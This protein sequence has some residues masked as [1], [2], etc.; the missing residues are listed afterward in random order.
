MFLKLQ[1]YFA[2]E[3]VIGYFFYCLQKK[4]N[5]QIHIQSQQ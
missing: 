5:K 4:P 2:F 1:V 3:Y